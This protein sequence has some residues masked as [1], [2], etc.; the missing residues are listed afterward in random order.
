MVDLRG[1]AMTGTILHDAG[2]FA[3][4]NADMRQH[5]RRLL[6]ENCRVIPVADGR[7][8]LDTLQHQCVDLVLT[9]V[10]IPVLDRFSLLKSVRANPTTKDIPIVMLSARAGEEGLAARPNKLR[11]TCKDLLRHITRMASTPSTRPSGRAS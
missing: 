1:S 9:D 11:R 6:S 4:D 7:K 2:G 5:L 3:D 10:M 8:A